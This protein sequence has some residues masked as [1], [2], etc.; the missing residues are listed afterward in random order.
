MTIKTYF[1]VSWEGPVLD[2][3]GKATSKVESKLPQLI[4]SSHYW[5]CFRTDKVE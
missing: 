1:D 5:R 4:A 2:G 3:S